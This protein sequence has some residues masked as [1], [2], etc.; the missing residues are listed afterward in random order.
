MY[1]FYVVTCTVVILSRPIHSTHPIMKLYKDIV[2]HKHWRGSHGKITI[3][4][5]TPAGLNHLLSLENGP[6]L[7]TEMTWVSLRLTTKLNISWK[8]ACELFKSVRL[9]R[10]R[11]W[12]FHLADSPC[13]VILMYLRRFSS[14]IETI[15]NPTRWTQA[16]IACYF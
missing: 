16:S 1:L 8:K 10:E 2:Y 14:C 5:A 12:L 6:S 7:F 4:L 15:T 3:N 11:A 9:L 13:L